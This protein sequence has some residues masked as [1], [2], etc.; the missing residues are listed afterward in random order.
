MS[1]RQRSMMII[2]KLSGAQTAAILAA[3]FAGYLAGA[4]AATVAA[5]EKAGAVSVTWSTVGGKRKPV[6]VRLTANGY[7]VKRGLVFG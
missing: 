3:D 1:K 2:G 6:R 7:R 4:R 5:L